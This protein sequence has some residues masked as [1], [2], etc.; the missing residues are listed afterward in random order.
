MPDGTCDAY[1]AYPDDKG[2]YPGVVMLMDAVGIR[3]QME[4]MARKLAA[5]GYFVLLPNEFYRTGRA[6]LI[7]VTNLKEPANFQREIGKAVG[8]LR[9]L[10]PELMMN[11]VGAY[12]DFLDA[13]PRVAK[14]KH[15]LTGYCMGGSMAFRAAG[16]FPDRIASAGVF[17]AGGLASDQPNSP[18]LLAPKIKARLYFGHADK[19]AH[20]GPEAIEKL[21]RVLDAAGVNYRSELYAGCM[22]GYTME[23]LPAYNAGGD[24][25]HWTN[26]LALLSSAA[27]R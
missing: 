15:G 7:D 13:H 22:H 2:T 12:L 25:R 9:E 20:M 6:P 3:P 26:L 5:E 24:E 18:H 16:T 10:T 4:K 14:G 11:D 17:H 19:D 27:S 21:T 1:L 8:F 23:D